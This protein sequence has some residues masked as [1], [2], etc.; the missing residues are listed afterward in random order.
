MITP[1]RTLLDQKRTKYTK[2]YKLPP[3]GM[4]KHSNPS[5]TPF[6]FLKY[7]DHFPFHRPISY[8]DWMRQSRL[9][10]TWDDLYRRVNRGEILYYMVNV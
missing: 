2:T 7:Q 3:D 5:R 1:Q 10:G 4:E 9:G 8:R 6:V